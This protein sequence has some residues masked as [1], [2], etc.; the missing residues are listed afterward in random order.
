MRNLKKIISII[1]VLAIVMTSLFVAPTTT[2]AA[3]SVK[4]KDEAIAWLKSQNN[5]TYDFDGQIGTQCVEFVKAYVN[6]LLTGNAWT[7]S[8]KRATG[9]GKDIWKNSLWEELGWKVYYNDASFMPQPGDIFSAGTSK[10]NHTGVVIS[11]DLKSAVI[12]DANA[13]DKDPSNGDPVYIHTINWKSATSDSA[14]G[15]THFIRPNFS[16]GSSTPTVNT[17]PN[18]VTGITQTL[19]ESNGNLTVSWN[20]SNVG[21]GGYYKF[22][23]MDYKWNTINETKVTGTSI[24]IKLESETE[25]AFR[26]HAYNSAGDCGWGEAVWAKSWY[27]AKLNPWIKVSKNHLF[28]GESVSFSF[29]ANNATSY[30]ITIKHLG[31]TI[32][33]ES[34]VKSGVSYTFNEEGTYTAYITARNTYYKQD[35]ETVSFYIVDALDMGDYFISKLNNPVSGFYVASE[36]LV[37]A[38]TK[39]NVYLASQES[40]S[41]NE[42]KFIWQEDGSYKVI[43]VETKLYLSLN[44]EQTVNGTNICCME[45]S[46]SDCQ[47]WYIRRNISGYALVPKAKLSSDLSITGND[48]IYGDCIFDGANIS[49]FGNDSV[50]SQ[51]FVFEY[52]V[53]PINAFLNV[54]KKELTSKEKLKFEFGSDFASSYKLYATYVDGSIIEKSIQPNS[55]M[56]FDKSGLYTAY[57]E[58]ILEDG[59]KIN[60]PTVSFYNMKIYDFGKSF[61]VKI[62]NV[63]SGFYLSMDGVTNDTII[64]SEKLSGNN[65]WKFDRQEDYSYKITNLKTGKVLDLYDKK[66]EDKTNI[67]G[68]PDDNSDTQKWFITQNIGG[69]ALAPKNDY[70]K[71]LSVF[72][73]DTIW[74]YGEHKDGANVVLFDLD[75]VE[76]QRFEFVCESHSFD[77]ECDAICNICNATRK[78]SH[79]YKTITT[80]ATTSNDGSI[81]E[82]CTVCGMVAST[83]TIKYAKS[84]KL[85]INQ[86][87]YDGKAKNPT[88]TVYDSDGKVISPLNYGVAYTNNKNVGKGIATVTFKGNYSGVIT[89]NFTIYPKSTAI[90]KLTAGKK[91]LK[92]SIKK[93]FSQ[94][95]GYEIQYSTSKKFASSKSKKVSSSK[96]TSVTLKK[97]KAKKTY[98]VRVRTYKIVDSEKYCSSWSTYKR[99]KTK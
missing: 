47:S 95:T 32:K 56:S 17:K 53:S 82:K 23:W 92:V 63:A 19:D 31:E 60:T 85:S 3:S 70:T 75:N 97:L 81:V 74:W 25:Y 29:D 9:D 87:I 73:N 65:I 96:R 33:T 61:N 36:S 94:T 8:W 80:K 41:N 22:V 57:I 12:A 99:K 27:P 54:D 2:K 69:F 16:S 38:Q 1:I 15:A 11:S 66:V 79:S 93:Q 67:I 43:N 91:K 76:S 44:D 28:L 45:N 58:Y 42:W 48:S 52:I 72:E 4:T 26:I 13:R 5:A 49:L 34:D 98:Y 77:E 14:Y 50:Q 6:W 68:A 51:R 18:P 84:C 20:A 30:D 89:V 88:V 35:S 71:Y 55:T 24:T 78:A 64:A 86:Y 83:T 62:K 40:N 21:S 59:T 10:G 7:D 39:P 46:N 37:N 90:S